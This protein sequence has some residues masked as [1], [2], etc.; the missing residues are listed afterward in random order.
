MGVDREDYELTA[1]VLCGHTVCT[2]YDV[3]KRIFHIRYKSVRRPVILNSISQTPSANTVKNKTKNRD[4]PYPT[5]NICQIPAVFLPHAH[6]VLAFPSHSL[7]TEGENQ[8]MTDYNPQMRGIDVI[9]I[10]SV[11]VLDSSLQSAS[12]RRRINTISKLLALYVCSVK[13]VTPPNP[14]RASIP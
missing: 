7:H 10:S 2:G 8:R 11:A 12:K 13:V 3:S 6:T 9:S 4:T 5:S 1:W 14:L